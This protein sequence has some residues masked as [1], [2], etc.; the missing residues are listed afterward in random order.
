MASGQKGKAM[1]RTPREGTLIPPADGKSDEPYLFI[2][3]IRTSL[4]AGDK[5]CD[6][7]AE[8][9]GWPDVNG[10][11]IEVDGSNVKVRYESGNER[12]KLHI[13]LRRVL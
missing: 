1:P 6:E 11:V 8:V 13:N 3:P 2:E 5:V 9:N 7:T 12:W 4:K 10:Y